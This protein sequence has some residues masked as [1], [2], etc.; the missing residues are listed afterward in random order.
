M[1]LT[2][3]FFLIDLEG[4]R[5]FSISPVLIHVAPWKQYEDES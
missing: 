3:P 1:N 4:I 2:Q 5:E